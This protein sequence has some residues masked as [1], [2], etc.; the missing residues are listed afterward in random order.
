MFADSRESNQEGER[1]RQPEMSLRINIKNFHGTNSECV[2][3]TD[4]QNE[5]AEAISV[6]VWT[7][8]ESV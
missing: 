7:F 3:L 4:G 1:K 2:L 6:F 8:Q 5:E